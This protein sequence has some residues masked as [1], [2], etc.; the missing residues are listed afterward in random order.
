[1]ADGRSWLSCTRDKTIEE[2]DSYTPYFQVVANQRNRKK[3]VLCLRADAIISLWFLQKNLF[4]YE[5]FGVNQE[6]NF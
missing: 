5:R 6:D 3:R 1:M 2:W 4:G